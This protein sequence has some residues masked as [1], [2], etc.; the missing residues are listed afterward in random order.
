MET[1]MQKP[2]LLGLARFSHEV[3]EEIA[4]Q[5]RSLSDIDAVMV[6]MSARSG[7][8]SAIFLLVTPDEKMCREFTELTQ[9]M[10]GDKKYHRYTAAEVRF[11]AF[12]DSWHEFRSWV[13]TQSDK[14][15]VQ[16]PHVDIM[17]VTP[18]WQKRLSHF[19][20]AYYTSGPLFISRLAEKEPLL[21]V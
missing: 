17:V 7:R 1:V 19:E 10:L 12:C 21:V 4:K 5:I 18:D 8:E 6:Y 15:L 20:Q 11:R 2:Y 13:L 16:R 3:L 14:K 9:S